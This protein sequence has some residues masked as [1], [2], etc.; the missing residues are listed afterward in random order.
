M[1]TEVDLDGW[2]MTPSCAFCESSKTYPY[3][4]WL[5]GPEIVD[6]GGLNGPILPQNL[7]EKVGGEAANLFQWFVR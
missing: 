2:R 6:F 1:R 7:V 3:P 4:R 5:A